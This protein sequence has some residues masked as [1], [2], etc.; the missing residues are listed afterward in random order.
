MKPYYFLLAVLFFV[1]CEDVIDLELDQEE[2]RLIIDAVL[3]VD[4]SK[5]FVPV[6]VKV[7]LTDNYFGENPIANLESIVISYGVL[8]NGYITNPAYSNLAE[9]EPG[10]GIYVPDPNYSSDQRIRTQFVNEDVTFDLIVEYNG[11]TYYSSTNYIPTVPF[12]SVQQGTQTLFEDE[13]EIIVDFTD[14]PDRDDFYLFDFDNGNY[15]VS[16]DKF[17]KG[18]DFSF[19]Y[20]YDD[21]IEPGDTL[22]VKILG[23]DR[24]FYNYMNL[25]LQQTDQ[26]FG[27][28]D[29]PAATIRGNI[30]Y[31]TDLDNI[32]VFDNTDSTNSFPL[33]YF[34]V[35][36]EYSQTL[37][38]E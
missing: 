33:G 4:K 6:E 25:L 24:N 37:V 10:S 30:F 9:S 19:S 36:Q 22:E 1:S 23:A 20:F 32:D 38:I 18:Q 12:N 13:I 34:A 28:F 29:T 7:S 16:E 21:P 3:R 27:F 17:Y 5:E 8:E 14:N 26:N 11:K 35:I 15:L 2:P 31:V